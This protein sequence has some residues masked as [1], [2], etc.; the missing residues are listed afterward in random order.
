MWRL[1]WFWGQEE[2]PVVPEQSEKSRDLRAT[3]CTCHETRTVC[4]TLQMGFNLHCWRIHTEI[5]PSNLLLLREDT[6]NGL[7]GSK[8]HDLICLHFQWVTV[9]ETWEVDHS[10]LAITLHYFC[11]PLGVQWLSNG[12][13]V[14]G[15]N[16]GCGQGGIFPAVSQVLGRL[17]CRVC[18]KHLFVYPGVSAAALLC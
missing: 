11:H 3:S 5:S 1:D 16:L 10:L 8:G 13:R 15:W 2:L 6:V 7:S 14:Q 18:A 17:W 9:P 12:I 4:S